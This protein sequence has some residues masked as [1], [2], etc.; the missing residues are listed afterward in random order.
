M[1][2]SGEWDDLP[3]MWKKWISEKAQFCTAVRYNYFLGQYEISLLKTQTN[4]IPYV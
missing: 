4:V 3:S 1:W 2:E